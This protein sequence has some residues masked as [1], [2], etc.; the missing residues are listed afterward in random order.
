M[1]YFIIG[2]T[3]QEYLVGGVL[4]PKKV[5]T[6][7][8]KAKGKKE[9]VKIDGDTLE[10]LRQNKVFKALEATKK[11]RVLDKQPAWTISGVDR[12]AAL[13]ARIKEL[14]SKKPSGKNV[15]LEKAL[16]EAK[17]EAD[18]AKKEADNAK[19]ETDNATKEAQKVIDELRA[20]LAA[21]KNQ[22]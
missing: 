19:K 16:K 15:D 3:M 7:E 21:L 14:E 10:S 4:L 2:Y 12:E 18:N 8:E 20:E 17:K 6:S 13:M 5:Y 22:G 9:A 11:I 1:D